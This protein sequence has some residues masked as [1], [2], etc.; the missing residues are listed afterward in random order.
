MERERYLIQL[1]TSLGS[2]LKM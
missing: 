2:C 1:T